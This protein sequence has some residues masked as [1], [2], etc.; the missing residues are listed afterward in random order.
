MI[1][2]RHVDP[3]DTEKIRSEFT[4]EQETA[5]EHP[6]LDWAVV[7]RIEENLKVLEE[8]QQAN[9]ESNASRCL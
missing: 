7:E 1:Q 3:K 2:E 9:S 4:Q 5:L 6:I 8:R